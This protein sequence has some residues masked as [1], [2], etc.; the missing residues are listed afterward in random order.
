MTYAQHWPVRV[1]V[2]VAIML[3]NAGAAFAQA[4]TPTIS[5]NAWVAIAIIV[6][7]VLVILLFI[8]GALGI[9]RRDKSDE[10]EAGVGFLEG[11]DEDDEK[12]KKKRK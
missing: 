6:G 11:I 12:P 10:D 8:G 2:G 1:A 7:L 3:S 9:S 5:G 4:E